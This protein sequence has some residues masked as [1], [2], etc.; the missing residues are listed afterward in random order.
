[1][2]KEQLINFKIKNGLT[3]NL[4]VSMLFRHKNPGSSKKPWLQ[5][6]T[7]TQVALNQIHKNQA[8]DNKYK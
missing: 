2:V 4:T 7:R 3:Y 6:R 1:M 5:I 8:V